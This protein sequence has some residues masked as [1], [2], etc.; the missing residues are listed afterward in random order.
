MEGLVNM[1]NAWEGV[2]DHSTKTTWFTKIRLGGKDLGNQ[3][4]SGRSISVDSGC[5]LPVIE[6]HSV[7]SIGR[8]SGELIV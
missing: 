2:I 8:V 1:D 4:R 7:S 5:V 3:T 6:A